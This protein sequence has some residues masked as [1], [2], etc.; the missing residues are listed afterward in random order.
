MG[1]ELVGHA[2]PGTVKAVAPT[3]IRVRV[4]AK[5]NLALCVGHARPD[6]YHELGTVYHAINL[7]DELTF[8]ESGSCQTRMRIVGLGQKT[9]PVDD[10]NLVIKAVN[11]LQETFGPQNRGISITVNKKIPIAGGMAG[12]SADCAATLLGAA[13][14]WNLPAS[15]EDLLELGAKLGSDVP[16]GL[17]GGSAI[18]SQRGEKVAGIQDNGHY[19]WVVALANRGLSTPSVFKRFDELDE[20]VGTQIPQQIFTALADGDIQLLAKCLRNDLQPAAISLRPALSEVLNAGVAAGALAGLVSGSGP[21]C[22][23][24]ADSEAVAKKVAAELV[25]HPKVW[26][27][28]VASGPVAGAQLI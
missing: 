6:G 24:L 21:T 23:F 8:A 25:K 1:D 27:T 3:A 12:G 7:F 13:K 15:L 20:V 5:I 4:P 2:N 10:S 18:G 14:F 26:A 17:V 22:V 19:H 11:L 28:E 16:F 9:L